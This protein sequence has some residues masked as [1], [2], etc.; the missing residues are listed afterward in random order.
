MN[1]KFKEVR[2]HTEGEIIETYR[3]LN[4]IIGY[5]VEALNGEVFVVSPDKV[6]SKT[7]T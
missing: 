7:E 4:G 2:G 5:N 1:I 6:V 3:G